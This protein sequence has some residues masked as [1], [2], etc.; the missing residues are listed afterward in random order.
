MSPALDLT[1]SFTVQ[2]IRSEEV[3]CNP[4]PTTPHICARNPVYHK[5]LSFCLYN[6]R[7]TESSIFPIT[8][9]GHKMYQN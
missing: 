3:K 7:I 2:T 8:I 6:K 4:P 5:V 1:F 9:R